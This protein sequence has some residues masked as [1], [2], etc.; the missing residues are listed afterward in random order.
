MNEEQLY[1][2]LVFLTNEYYKGEPKV[3][4]EDWDNLKKEYETTFNKVFDYQPEFYSKNVTNTPHFMKS[5][6]GI[7]TKIF[8]KE[9]LEVYI[10]RISK[11]YANRMINIR[12]SL[13]Y[14]GES[15]FIMLDDN[16]DIVKAMTK[17]KD[18]FGVDLTAIF[19]KDAIKKQFPEDLYKFI[20][21]NYFRCEVIITEDNFNAFCEYTG[22]QYKDKRSLVPGM[23]K[24]ALNNPDKEEKE[25]IASHLTL[26]PFHVESREDHL[27]LDTKYR[28]LNENTDLYYSEHVHSKVEDLIENIEQMQLQFEEKRK[29]LPFLI[30]G[31]IY[32][33]YM[34]HESHMTN[35][36]VPPSP[37]LFAYKF[38]SFKTET[39]I[40]DIQFYF[41]KKSGI[42]TPVAFFNPIKFSG[43]D[44]VKTSLANVNRLY[45]EDFRIGETIAWSYN[46]DVMGYIKKK[47]GFDNSHL[48]PFVIP[49]QCPHCNSK[50]YN[51]RVFLKCIN[52]D[53]P[54]MV[55]SKAINYVSK[56]GLKNIEES[57]LTAIFDVY[58]NL[59]LTDLH[60]LTKNQLMQIP[61]FLEKRSMNFIRN[62]N[63]RERVFDYEIVGALNWPQFSTSSAKLCFEVYSLNDFL[64]MFKT[65]T[66]EEIYSKLVAIK[67][68]GKVTANVFIKYFKKDMV[69]IQQLYSLVYT[70]DVLSKTTKPTGALE[71][72]KFVISGDFTKFDTKEEMQKL[73]EENGGK[74]SSSVSKNTH[75]LVVNNKDGAQS[76]VAKAKQLG[77]PIINEDELLALIA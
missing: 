66:D 71:G 45:E 43:R 50:L 49:T 14:D 4:D 55:A 30:D 67:D 25:F 56:M 1:Q 27:S 48:P 35:D 34:D 42:M 6:S 5:I 41:S 70:V 8:N 36:N 53:C 12:A 15:I 2:K 10:E 51:D 7:D 57:T 64:K 33:L 47:E 9:E 63:A 16:C 44:F 74:I 52:E 77:T 13:K 26:V 28:T 58:P 62:I 59:N 17:G 37:N 40:E 76:K 11:K 54:G 29:D 31:I 46:G 75:Y 38:K 69:L 65:C 23:I 72:F 20:K 61:S 68:I 32:E 21:G 19:A 39:V 24:L 73:I 60:F 3:S 22:R 18:G